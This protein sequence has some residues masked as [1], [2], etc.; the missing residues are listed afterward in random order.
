M[1]SH[2]FTD[3]DYVVCMNEVGGNTSQKGDGHLGGELLMCENGKSPHYRINTKRST[4]Q[5]LDLQ[6]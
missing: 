6:Y 3:P 1:V 2:D 5:Y 4:I